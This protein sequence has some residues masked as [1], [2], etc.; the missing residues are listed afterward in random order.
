VEL[1][2]IGGFSPLRGFMTEE[3]YDHV[4]DEMRLPEQ[5]LWGLP[6]V[7]DVQ[8]S[9]AYAEGE[10]VLLSYNGEDLAV[11]HVESIFSPDKAREAKAAFGTSE[12]EHPG[13][14]ELATEFGSTYLGGAISALQRPTREHHHHSPEEIRATLPE[15]KSVIAFQNRNPI[16]RAHYELIARAPNQVE[17]SCVLVHPTCGPTQPGD[18]PS[19]ERIRTYKALEAEVQNPDLIW[20]FLPYSMKMAGPREVI[21]HMIIRKNFGATHFIIGRDMAGT[22]STITGED[23]YGPYDA[24]ELAAQH[25]EELGMELVKFENVVYTEEHGYLQESEAKEKGLKAMKLSGTEFRRLM[26]AGEHVPEW[27]AFKCVIDILQ[28]KA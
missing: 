19:D 26:R 27:F 14:A 22:K 5:Q 9:S 4:L 1:L 24:H 8:D 28:G 6:V 15:G 10:D 3:V 13:V 23:Y 17:N 25:E 11:L 18:I 21:Q 2:S 7:L 12:L 16:H 20:S